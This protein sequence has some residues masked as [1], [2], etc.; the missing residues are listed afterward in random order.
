MN[1]YVE[2]FITEN[3]GDLNARE[4]KCNLRYCEKCARVWSRVE[5]TAKMIYYSRMDVSYYGHPEKKCKECI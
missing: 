3:R 2:Q 1:W 5:F 4:E